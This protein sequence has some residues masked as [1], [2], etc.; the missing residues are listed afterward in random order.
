M[1][2]CQSSAFPDPFILS[3]EFFSLIVMYTIQQYSQ[4]NAAWGRKCTWILAGKYLQGQVSTQ[5][6]V[7]T[8][9]KKLYLMDFVFHKNK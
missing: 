9:A 4:S 1:A 5:L 7:P 8:L 2:V 6:Y 3:Y